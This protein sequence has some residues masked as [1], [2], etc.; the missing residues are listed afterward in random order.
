M[1]HRLVGIRLF[2]VLKEREVYDPQKLV[3]IVLQQSQLAC[4]VSSQETQR[5]EY[6]LVLIGNDED[7][8]AVCRSHLCSDFLKLILGEELVDGRGNLFTCNFHPYHAL[9]A[10]ASDGFCQLVD[11]L[12]RIVLRSPCDADT[13]N[14]AAG[15]D[16]IGKHFE[17]AVL[18]QISDILQLESEPHIRFVASVA[19]HSFIV[20][21]PWE[22][23]L[24]I[25][26]FQFFENSLEEAFL[27]F[28]DIVNVHEGHFQVYLREFRLTVCTQVFVTETFYDLH[29]AVG[30][31]YHQQ[32][33]ISLR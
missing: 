14:A 1:M 33:L 11:L 4:D 10:V 6:H 5:I 31:A 26:A 30:S 15:C 19:L 20:R 27:H 12:S 23:C 16:S 22:R 28:N 24:H 8:I 25:D 2:V 29:I 32:L 18:H 17:F 21:D 7:Q 13:A 9:G 3:V